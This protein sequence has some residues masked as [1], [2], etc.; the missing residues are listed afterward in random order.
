MMPHPFFRAPLF[1]LTFATA[2]LPLGAQTGPMV[3][4]VK[5]TEAH[6]LYRPGAVE[7]PLRLTVLD[8]NAQVV[9]TSEAT[10][11]DAEDYVA[12]FH[13]T[14][15]QAATEYTYKVEDLTGGTAVEIVGPEDGLKF[16][17]RIP[18]GTKGVVT[19]A[20]VSCANSSSEPV[21]E[22]IG[23][24]G[25][26]Q[27]V[28]GGDTPYIDVQDLATSRDKQQAFLETPFMRS[29]IRGTSTVGTWDDHDFGLN[30]GNGVNAG[31]RREN[32]REA[33]V[34]YRAH[35]QYGTGVE[36]VYHKVDLGTM[37]IFLLDPRWWSQT[38]E[39]PVDAAKRTC[40][41]PEQWNWIRQALEESKA[42][43]KV[44]AMGQV[45]VDKKNGESD[46]MFTYQHERD[47]LYDFIRE[48]KIPGVVLLGGD[49][50]VSR[51]LIHRQR[52]GY[53][54][55]DFV[56]SPAHTSVIPSLDVTH[57]NLEW[58]S[59][60]PRQF[61]TLTADTRTNPAVMTARFYLA[62]GTIQREVTIPYDELT[63]KEGEGLGRDLRAWW[64]F[65]GDL[66]NRS[67]L[68]SRFD[69]TAVNGAALVADGG[70]R[71]GAVSFSRSGQQYLRIGRQ[72]LDDTPPL[73]ERAGRNPL[74]DNG[75]AHT[76]S[77]WC[78]PT[79]LPPHGGAE[80]HFLL[81][82][83]LGG[84]TAAGYVL[85]AGFRASATDA[86]KVNLE[87]HTVTLQPAGAASTAQPTPLAQGPFACELD[88]T[89]FTDR[90]AHVAMTFDST[91]LR[92]Y[93]DGDEVAAHLLPLAGPAAETAGLILGGHRDGTGR[94][95]DG[96]IDEVALWSRALT[97]VEIT[98]LHNSGT[99]NALPTE[100]GAVDTDGD[101]LED[102]WENLNG[103]DP[104][105]GED[106]LVDVD[107]DFVPAWLERTVGTHPQTDDSAL[108]DYIR[109]MISPG[110]LSVP[111]AFRHPAEGT[112]SVRLFAEGAG[113][114]EEWSR[115]GPSAALAGDVFSGDFLFSLPMPPPAPWFIRYEI[116]P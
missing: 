70:L 2:V 21:W 97:A 52:I 38:E 96:M 88:R 42:P 50:H 86:S 27:M 35:D 79:A 7:K 67:V 22:R 75:A 113:D 71:G 110:A 81:E 18:T 103:L 56:T 115:I 59:Q 8:A 32:T 68:G 55:H 108:Y 100:I 3:G 13:I 36:G 11:D 14:G 77:L 84:S 29:L 28:L 94:N 15:L 114:L 90:W 73:P 69:A 104:E 33:F 20:F 60:E 5:T 46:D 37:E 25:V 16:K 63:P 89:I 87:L 91:R 24:L 10:S 9:G 62:N 72:T 83:A 111:M 98:A 54:L 23:L 95:F 93:V 47:A 4:T 6:F 106:A 53:D 58:S 78:K 34:E 31:D 99:P 51:H 17:T 92:L 61:M 82:T 1:Y 116:E 76:F 74:H 105:D 85:S 39:S 102:W 49:I 66:E 12:K 112:L 101:T 40:F 107:G 48:K 19:A 65:D 109:E 44:L 26:D 41:G 30:N 43:F 64:S 80:R 45:W 57:P